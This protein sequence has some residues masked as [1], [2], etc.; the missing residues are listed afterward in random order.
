MS[1]KRKEEREQLMKDISSKFTNL[2]KMIKSEIKEAK[3]SPVSIRTL[4]YLKQ[5]TSEF[6]GYKDELERHAKEIEK[7]V[8]EMLGVVTDKFE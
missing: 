4:N 2:K 8:K 6:M 1:E 5:E 7:L 3:N